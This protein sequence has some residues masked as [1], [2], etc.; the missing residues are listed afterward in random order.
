MEF[1]SFGARFPEIFWNLK[2]NAIVHATHS[3]QCIDEDIIVGILLYDVNLS[4]PEWKQADHGLD[5]RAFFAIFLFSGE[6]NHELRQLL[7]LCCH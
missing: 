4:F 7:I 3:N 2:G 6:G 1:T 5:V